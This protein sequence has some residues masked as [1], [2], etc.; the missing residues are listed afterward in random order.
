MILSH[1]KQTAAQVLS[2]N[3]NFSLISINLLKRCSPQVKYF[4]KARTRQICDRFRHHL[5]CKC[6]A[7]EE[8]SIT[9]DERPLPDNVA[10]EAH[11]EA[12]ADEEDSGCEDVYGVELHTG[13]HRDQHQAGQ[14]GQGQRAGHGGQV[15]AKAPLPRAPP[16]PGHVARGGGVHRVVHGGQHQLGARVESHHQGPHRPLRRRRA[17]RG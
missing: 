8:E 5:G 2:K 4:S 1:L 7:E 10:A 15:R 11:V 3:K 17:D 13:H 14:L 9:R 12:A 16:V 6:P